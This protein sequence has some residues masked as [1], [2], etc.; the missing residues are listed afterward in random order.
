MGMPASQ[1]YR[2]RV[3]VQGGVT[4]R[5]ELAP[6]RDLL[7]VTRTIEQDYTRTPPGQ[8]TPNSNSYQMLV[9]LDYDDDSVWRWRLLVGAEA[10]TFA[11]K[12]YRPQNTLIAEVGVGWSPSGMT[13]VNTTLSRETGDAAQEGVS[14][15]TY[16]VARM[17]ID[18]E[19]LRDLLFRASFGLQ[20]ADFFQGGHQIGTTAGV[21]VT[22]VLNRSARLSFTYDQTDLHGSNIPS[23]TPVAGYSRGVGL[24][25]M[26]LGL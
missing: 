9:G 24:M 10:R 21:G 14:G 18:H 23:E 2:D 20:K 12:S 26:R 17:T 13:T 5:Y 11:S 1:A 4:V 16:S 25:T 15:F 7:F 22:W 3:V 19:Y 6:L 8:T